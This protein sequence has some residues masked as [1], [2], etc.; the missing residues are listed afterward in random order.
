LQKGPGAEELKQVAWGKEVVDLGPQLDENTGAFVETA[1][2]LKNLDLL[3]ACDTAVIHVA[4]ALAVPVWM[5]IGNVPDW[6]WMFDRDNSPAYPTL[7]LFRQAAFGDWNGVF[8]RLAD[9]LE[10][11]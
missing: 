1:A 3:V 7:R 5:A 8:K 2:V 6:R 11:Q 10:A 4:G 9:A